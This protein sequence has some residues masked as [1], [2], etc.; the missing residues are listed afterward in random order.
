MI[1]KMLGAIRSALAVAMTLT[2]CNVARDASK[3]LLDVAS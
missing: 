3:S 2:G 1:T